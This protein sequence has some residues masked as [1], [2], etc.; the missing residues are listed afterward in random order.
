MKCVSVPPLPHDSH[1]VAAAR[2]ELG[3]KDGVADAHGLLGGGGER[4]DE[5]AVADGALDQVGR[6]DLAAVQLHAPAALGQIRRAHPVELGVLRAVRR[7]SAEGLVVEDPAA[8][9][10]W[11]AQHAVRAPGADLA[12]LEHVQPEAVP[13]QHERPQQA[14]GEAAGL[15]V[16]DLCAAA[17]LLGGVLRGPRHHLAGR[18]D[19]GIGHGWSRALGNRARKLAPE[20]RA[21]A[22]LPSRRSCKRI[23]KK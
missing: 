16:A 3:C 11:V 5:P 15:A 13:Q 19:L 22:S 1:A 18:R 17:L 4:R 6:L 9:A 14:V 7:F 8:R 2:V 23:A 10:E 20:A 12:A 21:D